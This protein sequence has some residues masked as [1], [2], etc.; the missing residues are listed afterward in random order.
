MSSGADPKADQVK[1]RN[2]QTLSWCRDNPRICV[3]E[4]GVETGFMLAAYVALMFVSANFKFN[5]L[6]GPWLVLKFCL[7]FFSFSFFARLVSDDLGNK[8]SIAA[9]SGIGAKIVAML[10][11]KF[12]TW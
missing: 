10:I 4:A 8:I 1:T 2:Y 12:V 11:P 3:R 7:F 6:P 9:V 5:S